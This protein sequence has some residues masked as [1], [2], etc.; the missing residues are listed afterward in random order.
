MYI[1][2]VAHLNGLLTNLLLERE[3]LVKAF[4]SFIQGLKFLVQIAYPFREANSSRPS[5]RD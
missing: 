5:D 2:E 4:K 1:S 3:Y